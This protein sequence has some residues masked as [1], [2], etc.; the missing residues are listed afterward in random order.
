M[1]GKNDGRAVADLEVFRRDRNALAAKVFNLLEQLFRIDHRAVA[2]HVD[3]AFAED[4]GREQVQREFAVFVD[5]GMPRVIAA[6]IT[7]DHAKIRRDE[8][9]HTAFPLVAPVDTNDCTVCHKKAP[10][11]SRVFF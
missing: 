4:A 3:Y 2:E 1:V 9:D 7:D 6:L 5:N 11:D 10:F 8:I